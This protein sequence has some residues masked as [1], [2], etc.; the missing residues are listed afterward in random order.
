MILNIFY[1]NK[2]PNELEI[3]MNREL[4]FFYEYEHEHEH[5]HEQDQFHGDNFKYQKAH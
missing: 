4:K 1:V 2:D 3:V 5:E